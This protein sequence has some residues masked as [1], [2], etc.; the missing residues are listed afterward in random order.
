LKAR[1]EHR[2]AR[3]DRI[4]DCERIDLGRQDKQEEDTDKVFSKF[5]RSEK[6]MEKDP[7]G[8]GLGLYIDKAIVELNGG[9]LWFKNNEDFGVTF[10]FTIPINAKS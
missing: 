2:A 8:N 9:K 5:Y 4:K 7:E 10:F 3:R 1:V 6:A